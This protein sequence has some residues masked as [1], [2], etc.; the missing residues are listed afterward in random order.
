MSEPVR[1]LENN[2][3]ELDD[4]V[5]EA[6]TLLQSIHTN[7]QKLDMK[8]QNIATLAGIISKGIHQ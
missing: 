3:N 4:W 2:D 6:L 8:Y 1:V 5:A 7:N